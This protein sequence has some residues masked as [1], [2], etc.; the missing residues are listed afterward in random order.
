MQNL[1]LS[2]IAISDLVDQIASEVQARISNANIPVTPLVP[3]DN[4][5]YGDRAAAEHIG[6]TVQTVIA[7]RKRGEIPFYKYGRKYYYKSDE[8]DASLKVDAR[9][10]GEL[11]GR[12]IK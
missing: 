2:P 10:F 1:V 7:L 8:I 9:R 11:R 4:R 12:R 6:C 3:H 5:L